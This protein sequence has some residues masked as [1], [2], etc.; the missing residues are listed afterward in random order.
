M[1]INNINLCYNN[2]EI[3]KYSLFNFVNFGLDL[4]LIMCFAIF[5]QK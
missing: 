5:C 4:F 1:T 3:L 2:I